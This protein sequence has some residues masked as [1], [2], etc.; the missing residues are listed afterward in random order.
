MVAPTA[1]AQDSQFLRFEIRDGRIAVV[2]SDGEAVCPI[3][4]K[5]V[6][7]NVRCIKATA[8]GA[9]CH[10]MRFRYDCAP[11]RTADAGNPNKG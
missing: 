4:H 6:I 11:E 5:M 1:H 9:Q 3:G 10:P 7:T 2:T 8:A